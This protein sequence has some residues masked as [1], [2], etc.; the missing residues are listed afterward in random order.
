M[1]LLFPDRTVSWLH[2]VSGTLGLLGMASITNYYCRIIQGIV[3]HVY[4]DWVIG[5]D[6]TTKA[7][8][9]ITLV[10]YKPLEIAGNKWKTYSRPIMMLPWPIHISDDVGVTRLGIGRIRVA[11]VMARVIP[12]MDV[13]RSPH[14]WNH[15]PIYNHK[16]K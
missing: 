4:L 3:P 8:L 5:I 10:I 1:L 15:S 9:P 16:N 6:C 7:T 2:E 13:S 14:S 12:V 11:T